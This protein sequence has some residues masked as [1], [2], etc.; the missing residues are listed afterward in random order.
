[1][2]FISLEPTHL[3]LEFKD[4]DLV[5]HYPEILD[6]CLFDLMLNVPVNSYG[7][8]GMASSPNHSFFLVEL[9]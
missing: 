4:W 5:C 3:G 6:I 9:D 7:H 2:N 1:M 8:V